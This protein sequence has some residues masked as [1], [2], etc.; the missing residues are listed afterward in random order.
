MGIGIS[1][2]FIAVGAILAWAVSYQATG[3][4]IAV[5]GNILMAVGVLGLLLSL[6]FWSSIGSYGF[7]RR[8]TVVEE[9]PPHEHYR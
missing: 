5:V 2:F 9:P 3:I 7:A 1:L 6:L 8:E 4:D